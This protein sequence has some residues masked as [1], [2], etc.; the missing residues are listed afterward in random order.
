M[1]SAII[2][3][4][5]ARISANISAKY[6]DFSAIF[7]II[8]VFEFAASFTYNFVADGFMQPRIEILL[9]CL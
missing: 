5:S 4:I 2:S 7:G 6:H 3:K 9:I 8:R 1:V